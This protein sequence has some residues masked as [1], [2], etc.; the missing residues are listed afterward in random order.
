[1]DAWWKFEDLHQ[2]ETARKSG[3]PCEPPYTHLKQTVLIS[4]QL[5]DIACGL[6]YLHS[7]GVIHG[8]LKGVSS[9]N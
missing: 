5:G 2:L 3:C 4:H 6:G 1:M 9:H 8:D 7:L